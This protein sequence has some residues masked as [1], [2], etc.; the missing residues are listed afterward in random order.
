MSVSIHDIVDG[1]VLKI[2]FLFVEWNDP[3]LIINHDVFYCSQEFHLK[4]FLFVAING[5]IQDQ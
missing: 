1:R 5:A 3:K 4:E 2:Y